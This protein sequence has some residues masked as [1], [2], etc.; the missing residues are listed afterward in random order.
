MPKK[1]ALCIVLV[2]LV[3]SLSFGGIS[4]FSEA[5]VLDDLPGLG[6]SLVVDSDTTFTVE[7][8]ETVVSEGK[9]TLQG[10]GSAVPE[11]TVI[12]NGDLTIKSEVNCNSAKLTIQNNGMLALQ[13]F[14]VRLDGNSTVTV[15]NGENFSMDDVNV[16]VYGGYF[17]VS[18][19]GTL[20]SHNLYIK[21]QFD[22]TLISNSGECTLS[23][24]T[25]VANG[26][27]GKIEV[28]NSGDMQIHHGTFDVNY[29]GRIN[30]NTAAGNLVVE[31][32]SVDVSGASHGKKSDVNVIASN[33]TWNRCSFVNNNGNINYLH[34]GEGS[35]TNC[36]I[37]NSGADSSTI[38]TITAPIVLEDCSI[39]GSG[40]ALITNHNTMRVV[41]STFTTTHSLSLMNYG[42]LNAE[43]WLVQTTD[44]NDKITIYTGENGTISFDASFIKDVSAVDLSAV[45][46]EGQEFVESTGGIIDVTNNGVIRTQ[47]STADSSPN[48]SVYA[49]AIVVALIAI[50]II[51]L[52]VRRRRKS[53]HLQVPPP[54][55]PPPL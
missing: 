2:L 12:N 20:E 5:T 18:N 40:S 45:G 3:M 16:Q 14:S 24:T 35:L 29:G 46:P 37:Q 11:F 47:A 26:A 51:L 32:S 36:T 9:I 52:V 7:A 23:E 38:L 53:K 34:S 6:E 8:G 27:H 43:N 41:D 28:F 39:S 42:E 19:G 31:D 54:P 50:I 44:S 48:Y 55:P 4:D 17:Y 21:D 30:I 22:G 15:E 33:T 10:L 13:D 1:G 49:L 25:F